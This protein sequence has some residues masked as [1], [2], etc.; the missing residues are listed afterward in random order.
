MGLHYIGATVARLP[1]ASVKTGVKFTKGG[2][3][4]DD[5]GTR[6]GTNSVLGIFALEPGG[7]STGVGATNGDPVGF[8]ADFVHPFFIHSINKMSS[9]G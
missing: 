9:I 5:A 2:D 8:A 6:P 3:G 1:Q 4:V 7:E